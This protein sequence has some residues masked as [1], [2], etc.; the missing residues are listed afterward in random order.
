MDCA[1]FYYQVMAEPLL[2]LPLVYLLIRISIS[3][4]TEHSNTFYHFFV[5]MEILAISY[6][7]IN[8][9]SIV[10]EGAKLGEMQYLH[11]LLL[12]FRHF[13]SLSFCFVTPLIAAAAIPRRAKV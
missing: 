11:I 13:L 9:V 2:C 7:V 5:W 10:L 12:Y 1:L 4:L 8:A 3:R 6:V